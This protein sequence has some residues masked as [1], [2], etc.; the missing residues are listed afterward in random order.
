MKWV[1]SSSKGVLVFICINILSLIYLH[2]FTQIPWIVYFVPAGGILA[3][4]TL[5]HDY[6]RV[7]KLRDV[8]RNVESN[9]ERY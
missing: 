3:G 9:R 6:R 1:V 5:Y 2:S 7:E 8:I 4:L